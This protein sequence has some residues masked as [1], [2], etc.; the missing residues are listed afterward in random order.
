LAQVTEEFR[1]DRDLVD[2]VV[3]PNFSRLP[4]AELEFLPALESATGKTFPAVGVELESADSQRFLAD[5]CA[6]HS[7]NVRPPHTIPRLL[8]KFMTCCKT[9]LGMILIFDSVTIKQG[10]I[11]WAAPFD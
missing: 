9:T 8:G 5:L 10:S 2:T 7:I 1:E 6:A 11:Q 4:Y 3:P